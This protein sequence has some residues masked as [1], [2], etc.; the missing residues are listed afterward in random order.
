MTKE[1]LD[2][3]FERRPYGRVS[4]K[5]LAGGL[6]LALVISAVLITVAIGL[7]LQT[8]PAVEL[9]AE[10]D[11]A[12]VARAMALLR[13]QDPRRMPN[14]TVHTLLLGERDLELLLNHAARRWLKATSQVRLGSGRA[15]LR[16]SLH[17]PG[18]AFSEF[19]GGI[20]GRWLNIDATV[21][22]APPGPRHQ[23]PR[24]QALR[25][26]HLPLPPWLA[27]RAGRWLAARAGLLGELERT[28]DA[29]QQV[30]FGPRQVVLSYVWRGG[31][32]SRRLLAA[33]V[34]AGDQRRLRVYTEHLAA[35]TAQQ[36]VA[37]D[38]RLPL[39]PLLTSMFALAQQRTEAAAESGRAQ[40]GAD[41]NRAAL[42]VLT[43]LVIGRRVDSVL[44]DARDW[45]QPTLLNPTL[46]DRVDLPQHLLVSAVLA[47]EGTSPLSRAVGIYK[48]VADSQ[49][50][51]G[52]SFDDIAAD[53]SG[54]RI[55]T[56]AVEDPLALQRALTSGIQAADILPRVDDLPSNMP[57]PE[58]LRR[59]G[60]VG[61]PAY[62]AMIERI[63]QRIDALGLWRRLGIAAER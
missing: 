51:S 37:E 10:P 61:Q 58:F 38:G 23:L 8:T 2:A 30:S 6:L 49:G 4:L 56:L 44:P 46:V 15:E 26:G 59:F 3:R 5:S 28:A 45:P 52:F 29:V 33:F 32:E 11:H 54:T 13:A 7:A 21:V 9:A 39:A 19:F 16:T 12:D 35:L 14:G 31:G 60:G 63:D 42:M 41:E 18:T 47:A 48:E 57:E 24:L 27:E 40:T 22:Q 36:V 53:R 20:F 1:P 50:G 62:N 55:G 25:V 43:L 17:L 34:D